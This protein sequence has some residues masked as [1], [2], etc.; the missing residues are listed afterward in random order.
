M[1]W[2]GH[3]HKSCPQAVQLRPAHARLQLD[4]D[5][6]GRCWQELVVAQMFWG[7]LGTPPAQHVPRQL[8][9]CRCEAMGQEP[10]PSLTHNPQALPRASLSP[11]ATGMG[12]TEHS[13]HGCYP[14]QRK[15]GQ[16]LLVP[17]T[18]ALMPAQRAS[19]LTRCPQAPPPRGARPGWPLCS[20]TVTRAP[21]GAVWSWRQGE[22]LP[23]LTPVV[24][25]PDCSLTQPCREGPWGQ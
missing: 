25:A 5:T 6:P 12:T 17:S 1:A 21:R 10:A 24:P 11:E 14:A 23:P 2:G 13:G 4:P 22:A 7:G 19:P 9:K 15:G 3:K 20:P 18:A 8:P 16:S